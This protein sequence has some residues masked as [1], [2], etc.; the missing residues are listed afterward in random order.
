MPFSKYHHKLVQ[1]KVL[2]DFSETPLHWVPGEAEGSQV[3]NVQHMHLPS[4][5]LWFCR[6]YNNALP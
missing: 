5:V 1:R 3:M 2:F 6:L 4:G